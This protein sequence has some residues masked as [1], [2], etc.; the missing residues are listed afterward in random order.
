MHKKLSVLTL[1]IS[2]VSIPSVALAQTDSSTV[3]PTVTTTLKEKRVE[4]R[5]A[6][7][8]KLAE[9]RD[10]RKKNV[11]DNIDMRIK[12]INAKRTEQMSEHLDK[13]TQV[14]GRIS[15]KSAVLKAEG[16]NTTVVDAGIASAQSS[17][18]SAKVA[19]TAQMAKEYAIQITTEKNLG[20]A[21]K[22]V[23][24]QFRTDL[25]LTYDKVVA[26]HK[27]VVAV[28]KA[29]AAFSETT[30]TTPTVTATP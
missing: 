5:E 17:I 28:R 27:A 9:I 11:V 8:A 16:K 13:L 18:E 25:K 29:L 19:V 23:L 22:S 1:L 7:K 15:S 21:V 2:I 10:E 3:T 26:A 12:A 20:Q 14:L 30:V 4:A 6:F 24:L